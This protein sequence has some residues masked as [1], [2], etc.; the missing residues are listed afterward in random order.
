M[1]ALHRVLRVLAFPAVFAVVIGGVWVAG[2]A[3]TNSFHA[4][5][6]LTAA[7]MVLAGAACAAFALRRRAYRL[8]VAGGYVLAALAAGGYLGWSTLHD[9]VVDEQVAVGVPLQQAPAAEGERAPERAP[10]AS[11]NVELAAGRFRSGEHATRGRAAIVRL[12]GGRRVLTLTRFETSAGP[13]LRVRLAPGPNGGAGGA[14][15]LGALKGNRGDQQ[16]DL[17]R[18]AEIGGRTVVIWCRAFSV[19]FGHAALRD[20]GAA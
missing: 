8:P 13:D 16:Y 11:R 19:A 17:P 9:R 14:L 20:G 10:R 15:D 3:I 5:M 18:G 12:A 7:W 6:A 2:G 4:S 1:I